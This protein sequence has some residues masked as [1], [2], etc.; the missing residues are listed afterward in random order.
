MGSGTDHHGTGWRLLALAIALVAVAAI[1]PMAHAIAPPTTC[2]N[3][4]QTGNWNTAG[5]WDCGHVPNPG[6][7]VAIVKVTN[8]T[9]I[10]MDV[11]A[12]GI[13]ALSVTSADKNVTLNMAGYT[14]SVTGAVTISGGGNKDA[15]ISVGTGALSGASLGMSSSST[16]KTKLDVS[17]SG[18]V[19]ISG[20]VT[21]DNKT[22]KIT[23]NGASFFYIGG[24]LT[25]STSPNNSGA[26]DTKSGSTV[27]YNGTGSQNVGDFDYYNLTIN[28]STGTATR[29][30]TYPG[31]NKIDGSF[32][33]LAGTYNDSSDSKSVK[34]D[35]QNDGTYNHGDGEV[36]FDNDGAIISGTSSTTFYDVL[37]KKSV[38]LTAAMMNIA[39][40]LD[41][42]DYN[43]TANNNKVVIQPG[44]TL[45]RHYT[46][47]DKGY[48]DGW[49]QKTIDPNDPSYDPNDPT[50]PGYPDFEV[51][52]SSKFTPASIL[53]SD[54]MTV[55]V[56]A[57]GVKHPNSGGGNVLSRYWT[58]TTASSFTGASLK[59]Q[60]PSSDVNGTEANY[61]IGQWKGH[62]LVHDVDSLATGTAAAHVATLDSTDEL[63]DW[64]LGEFDEYDNPAPTAS[65]V[66]FTATESS[67]ICQNPGANE[68]V[69]ITGSNFFDESPDGPIA[70]FLYDP[71]DPNDPNS[72]DLTTT[73][74][75]PNEVTA[76]IPSTLLEAP[77]TFGILVRNFDGQKSDIL[78]FT[79]TEDTTAPSVSFSG[80]ST[81]EMT[82]TLCDPNEPYD[83]FVTPDSSSDLADFLDDHGGL[84]NCWTPTFMGNYIV[85]DPNDPNEAG[86]LIDGSTEIPPGSHYISVRYMDNAGNVG[87]N[88]K[89][90]TVYAWG[91]LDGDGSATAADLTILSN[92]LVH[93]IEPGQGSFT[94]PAYLSDLNFDGPPPDT[95]HIDALDLLILTNYL[96]GN[97]DCLAPPI[98]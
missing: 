53:S 76:T 73:W 22:D 92:Y 65:S 35:W 81:F 41:L 60:Y 8:D 66:E 19:T 47:Y 16:G 85:S 68:Q 98:D 82:Q 32:K 1:T 93:N 13:A 7:T 36:V 5:T 97:D 59:F 90:L 21:T 28:K 6:D 37:L 57:Y 15:K 79:V 24:N 26:L 40:E 91:D 33:L 63:S 78:T 72:V 95:P 46:H 67:S 86:T 62:W 74:N 39:N 48:I 49:L 70:V 54:A 27:V 83:P 58:I 84:D 80:S 94:N 88:T 51:G 18:S 2:T 29:L 10:T 89:T 34:G 43:V 64:T 23:L 77:G 25:T 56:R 20:D 45:V 75:D 17:A 42:D 96:A 38:V 12:T 50:A 9:T 11:D 44:A 52:T 55:M 4:V 3:Q 31:S 61:K 69:T 14:L 87:S 30:A 71:N